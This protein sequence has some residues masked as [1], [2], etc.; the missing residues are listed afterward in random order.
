MT[1]EE[2]TA[3]KAQAL[4]KALDEQCAKMPD[5]S[6]DRVG[7]IVLTAYEA[8]LEARTEELNEL[9]RR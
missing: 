3:L 5:L 4:T 6:R 1:F 9:A 8:M 7:L 2:R